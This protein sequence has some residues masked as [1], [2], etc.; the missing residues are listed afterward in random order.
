MRLYRT[1]QGPVLEHEGTF[2]RVGQEWDSLINRPDLVTY[3]R[4]SAERSSGD[5]RV[6]TQLLDEHARPHARHPSRNLR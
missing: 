4:H 3:L 1:R 5:D 6:G 2:H